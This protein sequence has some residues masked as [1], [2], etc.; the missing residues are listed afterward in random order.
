MPIQIQAPDGSIAEF[1]DGTPDAVIEG[2]MK[3]EYGSPKASVVGNPAYWGTAYQAADTVTMGGSTKLGAAGG[4]LVDSLVNAA[5]GEG[6]NYNDSYNK[7][8]EQQRA[9]QAAYNEENVIAKK[10]QSILESD[11]PLEKISIYLGSDASTD[12]TNELIASFQEKHPNIHLKIFP[13]RSG[14]AHIINDLAKE[15]KD[16]VFILT[17]ANVFFTQNTISNLVRHFSYAKTKQ[18]CDATT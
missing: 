2:V 7:V 4:A 3:Q 18:V 1:P 15:C 14:K 17:D 6:W 8:L 5:R 11:Y 16:D 13:G 10:I 9:N 12:K